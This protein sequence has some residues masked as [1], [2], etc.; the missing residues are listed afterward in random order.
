MLIVIGQFTENFFL[1]SFPLHSLISSCPLFFWPSGSSNS[2]AYIV[3]EPLVFL[4]DGMQLIITK[5]NK[6]GVYF[7]KFWGC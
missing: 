1:S 2:G 5:F 3:I 7:F 4:Q 6:F